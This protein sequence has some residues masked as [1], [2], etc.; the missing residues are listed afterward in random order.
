M[1]DTNVKG[2]DTCSEEGEKFN[3]AVK[4]C[5][6]SDGGKDGGGLSVGGIVG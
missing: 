4:E 3:E 1:C 6:V 2:C 5:T